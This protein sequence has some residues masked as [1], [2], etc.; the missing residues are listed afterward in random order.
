MKTQALRFTL[1]GFVVV[2]VYLISLTIP[3]K[4]LSGI[5]AGFPAVML[6]ALILV[7]KEKGHL[8]AATMAHAATRGLWGTTLG[9]LTMGILLSLHFNWLE[10]LTAG[11]VVW[12][13]FAT[14]LSHRASH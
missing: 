12:A 14:Y 11:L 4:A 7:G 10:A 13:L 9:S 2:C 5:M 8:E 1:G 6:T 3:L